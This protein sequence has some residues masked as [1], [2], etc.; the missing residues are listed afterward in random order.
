[1]CVAVIARNYL[2]NYPLIVVTNRDEF[3]GRETVRSHYWDD[4]EGVLAGRDLSKGGTWL[5][6]TRGGRFAMVTNYREPE[7]A[8]GPESRGALVTD[9]LTSR[10]SSRS[11]ISSISPERYSGY[12]LVIYDGVTL[13]HSSNRTD[14]HTE[15]DGLH[16]L[17]NHLL[18][19]PWPKVVA[20]TDV[21]SRVLQSRGPEPDALIEEMFDTNMAETSLLPNTGVPP[22]VERRLSSV[23]ICGEKYGTRATTIVALRNDGRLS[24]TE[25]AYG[26]AATIAG[27][28]SFIFNI[29][30]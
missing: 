6:V 26:P 19:T 11:F 21:V 30:V 17:S 22:D 9:F 2:E 14:T 13:L 12:N 16:G 8:P 3:H 28:N 23:F 25:Q 4:K 7:V 27:R 5:G 20:S 15:I 24:F 29:S 18:D 10:A 1:M